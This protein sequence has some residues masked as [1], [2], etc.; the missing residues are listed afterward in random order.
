MK[1]RISVHLYIIAISGLW[2]TTAADWCWIIH[3]YHILKL[4]PIWNFE[5]ASVLV[6]II[7]INV[8]YAMG[9]PPKA[10]KPGKPLKSGNGGHLA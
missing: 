8:Y 2:C 6:K 5:I 10:D 4:D 3:P 9:D 1:V 7:I